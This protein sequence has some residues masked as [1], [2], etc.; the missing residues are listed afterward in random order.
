MKRRAFVVALAFVLGVALNVTAQE[1]LI[2]EEHFDSD[3]ALGAWTVVV[4]D[5]YIDGGAMINVDMTSIATNAYTELLQD[6]D[7]LVYEWEVTFIKGTDGAIWTPAAGIHIMVNDPA[8]MSRGSSYLIWQEQYHFKIYRGQ[9]DEIVTLYTAGTWDAHTR[10]GI[11]PGSTHVF[12]VVY[13]RQ[14]GS[15]TVYRDGELMASIIDPDPVQKGFYLSLRTNQTTAAFNY[16][17]VWASD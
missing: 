17:K 9:G 16:L 6:A 14:L 11:V 15:L 10:A 7:R 3:A 4:G 2:Y 13:D 12:R 1:R 5:W 8:R